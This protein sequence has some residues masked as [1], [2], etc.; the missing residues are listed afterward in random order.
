MMTNNSKD[1]PE[2]VANILVILA[3]EDKWPV[4]LEIVKRAVEQVLSDWTDELDE[5]ITRLIKAWETSMDDD[6]TL[7]TLGLR[8]AQDLIR[9]QDSIGTP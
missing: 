6:N 8:R 3:D 9:G 7:Y 4:P 2:K 1:I 5:E